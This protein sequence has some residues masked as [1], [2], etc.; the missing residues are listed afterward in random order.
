MRPRA[1]LCPRR[2]MAGRWYLDIMMVSRRRG[3]GSGRGRRAM[4]AIARPLPF[5]RARDAFAPRFAFWG[6]RRRGRY[7]GGRSA[8]RSKGEGRVCGGSAMHP[9][10]RVSVE[11]RLA[12]S[13]LALEPLL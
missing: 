9:R 7:R 4:A 5:P 10:R 6:S 8:R 11:W 13:V 3:R 12:F 1:G 2:V